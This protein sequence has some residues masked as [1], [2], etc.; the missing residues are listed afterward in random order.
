MA[1]GD[2]KAKT[3]NLIIQQKL[4]SKSSI[5]CLT[6][7]WS[8]CV[9]YSRPRGQPNGACAT[10]GGIQCTSPIKEEFMKVMKYENMRKYFQ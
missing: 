3:L 5:C 9:K 2:N 10:G 4:P 7:N 8:S 1:T 6:I